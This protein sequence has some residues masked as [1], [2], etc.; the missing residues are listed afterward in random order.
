VSF[1]I[2]TDR[3]EIRPWRADD[4]AVMAQLSSDPGMMRHMTGGR[5]WTEDELDG[6]FTRQAATLAEFGHCLGAVE[7]RA[8]GRVIGLAGLQ[9]LGTTGELETGYWIAR[10]LWGRG[11]AAEAARGALR[12]A[13]EVL[14]GPRVV[15]ITD[16][17]NLASRRVMEK[18]GMTFQRRT[19][20]AA[21]GH[22]QPEIDVVLYAIERA[23]WRPDS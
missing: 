4:R 22:R 21:L 10:D 17:E 5:P 9:Y 7:E 6:F 2:T 18:I 16:P 20:G 15:A 23:E 1:R 8:T 3:L 12:H 19:T 14:D 11:F 13:F